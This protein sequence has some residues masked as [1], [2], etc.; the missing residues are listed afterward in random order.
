MLKRFCLIVAVL[1]V[2]TGPALAADTPTMAEAGEAAA[3]NATFNLG[4]KAYEEKRWIQ[5]IYYMRPLAESGDE[6]AMIILGNMYS[7]GLGVAQD[8]K[9]AFSLYHKAA[10]RNNTD[11]IVAVAAMYQKGLGVK[12]NVRIATEWYARA[13]RLGHR[14]GALYY[15]LNMYK[16][17]RG[18]TPG[19]ELKPD[20]PLAYKW[21]LIVSLHAKDEQTQKVAKELSDRLAKLLTPEQIAAGQK[22][23]VAWK[24]ETP[25][26]I[27][28][29]PSETPPADA[30]DDVSVP[31]VTTPQAP[32]VEKPAV[33][34]PVVPQTAPLKK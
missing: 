22:D 29:F 1:A 23:A 12:H 8:Y 15:A 26:Q 7:I 5:A 4:K 10:L 24:D 14:V 34:P 31:Q 11:A 30:A 6:R 28:A 18:K 13:A 17:N 27:G 9:Q 20:H 25:E 33:T 3:A 16:G 32:V 2:L 19:S 21:A